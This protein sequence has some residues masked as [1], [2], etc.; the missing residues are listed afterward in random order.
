MDFTP[1][2]ILPN[3]HIGLLFNARTGS[4]VLR[5]YL[6][7][8]LKYTDLAEMF[9]HYVKRVQ[10]D[11]SGE[12]KFIF[13]FEDT[14]SYDSQ[15]TNIEISKVCLEKLSQMTEIKKFGVFGVLFE[16]WWCHFPELAEQLSSRDD[17]QFIDLRRGDVLYG[18]LSTYISL[19]TNKFHND[20][21]IGEKVVIKKRNVEPFI[22]PLDTLEMGLWHYRNHCEIV[23]KYFPNTPVLYYEQ[24]QKTPANLMHLFSGIPK[25]ICSVNVTKFE[26]NYKDLV[27]NLKEVEDFYAQFVS[28]NPTCF[29]QYFG[30]V[31]Y[32]TIPKNQGWQPNFEQKN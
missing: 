31:P 9:N 29:P 30:Q 28:E 23:E 22:Y 2:P 18:L 10:I 20:F 13:D 14:R 5:N 7:Q 26:G 17:M 27:L 11:L 16:S 25:K 32:I 24:F 15:E 12:P 19:L 4:S 1:I 3:R 8:V 21:G 6:R